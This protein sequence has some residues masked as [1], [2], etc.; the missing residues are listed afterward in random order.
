[1]IE[2]NSNYPV[3]KTN[4]AGKT[5]EFTDTK[6]ESEYFENRKKLG[7][8]W[9][10]YDNPIEYKNNK[11]G[12]RSNEIEE[13]E[14]GFALGF[15]CSFSYGFGLHL[16]DTWIH[17]LGEE[18]NIPYLNLSCSGT[19]PELVF[20]NSILFSAYC[21]KNNIS[22]SFVGIQWSFDT[23]AGYWH[24]LGGLG[25]AEYMLFDYTKKYKNFDNDDCGIRSEYERWIEAFTQ[26]EVKRINSKIFYPLAVNQIWEGLGARVFN[27]YSTSADIKPSFLK[28]KLPYE[29]IE[30]KASSDQARDLRHPGVDEHTT[31]LNTMLKWL[32]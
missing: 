25:K 21:K 20:Y 29:M 19:G 16:E 11:F 27:Y 30:I 14:D 23:R 10:Y 2:Y 4:L 9:Y 26:F 31:I 15:G 8:S 28:E 17:R 3:L 5:F 1:M 6:E 12:Y 13:L 22:P 24:D 7:S 32:M 18:L